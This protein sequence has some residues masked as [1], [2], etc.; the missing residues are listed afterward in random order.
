MAEG[1]V[2][3]LHGVHKSFGKQQALSGLDLAV[4]PGEIVALLGPNGA[5]K[6]TALSILLGLRRPDQ[7]LAR[8]FGADPRRPA[9]RR[10]IGATPQETGFPDNISLR[11][12][13]GFAQA[14]Y[15]D[16]PSIDGLLDDFGLA[17][18][19]DRRLGGLS[20]GQRRLCALALAFAGRP[21]AVFLDEPTT[22]LDAEAR[23]SA[24]Q[25]VEAFVADGGTV[26]LTTHYLE[27]ADALGSR[28]VLIDHGR[29][30]TEGG[31]D[32]I[33]AAVGLR[34]LRF[35]ADRCPD[36]PAIARQESQGEQHTLWCHDADAATRALVQSATPFHDLEV[37]PVSLEEAIA[38]KLREARSCD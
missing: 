16:R 35:R 20:G 14:H 1:C 2:A 28:I 4:Y 22:G 21:R 3:E 36:L 34:R 27:E 6:T 38:I 10:S 33:K 30:I 23:R 9:A 18:L 15:G 5:G 13:L 7:G 32:E 11:E 37:A 8:L 24:W 26:F 29:L 12:L 25:V 19:A 31:V 17:A